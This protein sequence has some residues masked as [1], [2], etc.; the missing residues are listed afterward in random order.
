MR[1]DRRQ[2]EPQPKSQYS[3]FSSRPSCQTIDLAEIAKM[4]VINY[5]VDR[6]TY[7]LHLLY[8]LPEAS[9]ISILKLF[10][11][12]VFPPSLVQDEVLCSVQ[13]AFPR[14]HLLVAG[15]CQ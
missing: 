14:R 12:L 7:L 3:I 2:S 1:R 11:S 9:L 5:E 15:R 6:M 10:Q 8:H 13:R 4:A